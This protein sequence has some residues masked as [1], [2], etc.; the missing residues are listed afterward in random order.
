M[1]ILTDEA[2]RTE[3]Q[4]A[5]QK[6]RLARIAADLA[7]ADR[8]APIRARFNDWL[9]GAGFAPQA[10]P[11]PGTTYP[12][13]HTQTL[14]ECYLAAALAE[15]KVSHSADLLAALQE[16]PSVEHTLPRGEMCKC[17]QCNFVRMRREAIAK[18]KGGTS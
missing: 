12:G 6:I 9:E 2:L 15:R 8:D 18:T 5:R 13:A 16:G 10:T 11:H 14:W 4:A 7:N 3:H 17:S 1:N